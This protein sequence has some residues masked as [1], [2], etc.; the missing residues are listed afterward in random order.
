VEAARTSSAAGVV[1]VEEVMELATCRYIDFPGVGV[2]DLEAPQLPEKVLDVAT[3]RMFAE[4]TIME[5]IALVSRALHEYERADGFAAPAASEAAEAVPKGPAAG[6]ES[7]VDAMT[8]PPTSE[9][10]DA[11]LPQS[12]EAAETTNAVVAT[13]AAEVAVDV[14]G[15]SPSRTV[16][17]G[18]DE[19]R[20]PDEPTTAVQ[21][22]I[23]PEGTTKAA[24]PKI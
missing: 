5:M 9:R 24:S 8:P 17:A 3:K 6:T 1:T 13:G 10:R 18:D 2:I 15:S 22:Q 21:E 14:A 7:A 16:V 20:V 19:V 12:A 11:P 4:P 23:A